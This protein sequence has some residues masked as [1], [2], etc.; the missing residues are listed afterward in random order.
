ML[1]EVITIAELGCVIDDVI[2]EPIGGAHNDHAVA[3]ASV[4]KILVIV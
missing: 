4:K 1:Y 3:A 2:P